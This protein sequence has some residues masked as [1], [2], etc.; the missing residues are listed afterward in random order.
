MI[1]SYSDSETQLLR[2]TEQEAAHLRLGRCRD[3]GL[4]FSFFL[5]PGGL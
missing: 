1:D 5:L 3:P 2:E 4:L